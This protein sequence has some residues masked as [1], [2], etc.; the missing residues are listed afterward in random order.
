MSYRVHTYA[1]WQNY[2]AN[3]R[4]KWERTLYDGQRNRIQYADKWNKTGDIQIVNTW[5][6]R[7][8]LITI[9]PDDTMTLQGGR[10]STHWGGSFSCLD[11]RSMR[12]TIWKYAGIQVNRRNFK[13]YI[14]ERDGL[15]TP[16]KIQ[17]CRMCSQ[18]GLIDGWC[19]VL[20]CWSVDQTTGICSDH[21]D[22][23][24]DDKEKRFGRH[25]IPC[26]HGNKIGH[27]VKRSQQCYSCSG[28]KKRDYGNKRVSV[29]WDGSPIRVQNGNIYKQPLTD[30]ERMLANHVRS[31]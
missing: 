1:D 5:T 16:S 9:H 17:G 15:L 24:M 18:T 13:V 10:V 2:L 19:N 8:P 12:Y 7:H 27:T 26:Q 4:N 30:L 6:N 31:I 3:G 23:P 14:T 28:T 25:L 29:P 21:P 20:H 22:I 11:S